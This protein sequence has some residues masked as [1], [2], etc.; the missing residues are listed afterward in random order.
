MTAHAP[1]IISTIRLI[2][3][4]LIFASFCAAAP[5]EPT[6]HQVFSL[7]WATGYGRTST[8]ELHNNLIKF[9]IDVRPVI[10]SP[11]GERVEL[12]SV[13]LT[14]LGNAS[15]DIQAMLSQVGRADLHSG[16]AIL[17]YTTPYPGAL[18]AETTV[19]NPQKTLAYT[20]IGGEHGA[21]GTSLYGVYWFPKHA[22][23]EVYVALQNSSDSTVHVTASLGSGSAP[24]ASVTLA[25][26][27]SQV[28][29]THV[30]SP[31]NPS[32]ELF[33]SVVLTHDAAPGGLYTSGW[34]EAEDMG[35]SNMMTL[36]DPARSSG[37]RLHGTQ[38]FLGRILI[39]SPAAST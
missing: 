3:I 17:E 14:Q 24:F 28:I 12:P 32:A 21:K 25:P 36:Y 5:P 20:I 16:S 1:R 4:A 35:Y 30:P 8:I 33:G 26:H 7:Y 23:G 6:L 31:A 38:V 10:L 13:H 29:E 18:L 39:S 19:R 11:S 9:P 27:A 37:T 2:L 34:I 15:I 22:G